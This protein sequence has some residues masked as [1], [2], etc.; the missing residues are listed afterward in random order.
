MWAWDPT[1]IQPMSARKASNRSDSATE[2]GRKQKI[3]QFQG[4]ATFFEEVNFKQE[5]FQLLHRTISVVAFASNI[6][7]KVKIAAF[8]NSPPESQLYWTLPLVRRYFQFATPKQQICQKGILAY[9]KFCLKLQ[10][11]LQPKQVTTEEGQLWNP[12][13]SIKTDG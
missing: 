1:A 2:P 4:S 12:I 10:Q 8:R 6:L 11:L 3:T 9:Q 13:E 5:K 7:K